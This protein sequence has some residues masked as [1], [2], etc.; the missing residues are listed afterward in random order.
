MLLEAFFDY[1]GPMR[2]RRSKIKN[3][4]SEEVVLAGSARA[5]EIACATI[6][7]VRTAVGLR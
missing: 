7:R 4:D 1:F 2:D 3:S 6:E 5:R